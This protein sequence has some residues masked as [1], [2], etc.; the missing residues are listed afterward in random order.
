MKSYGKRITTPQA[1]GYLA[2]TLNRQCLR[3]SS[4]ALSRETWRGGCKGGVKPP[5]NRAAAVFGKSGVRDL[6]NSVFEL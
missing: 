5:C 2:I 6:P 4:G 1:G 3:K